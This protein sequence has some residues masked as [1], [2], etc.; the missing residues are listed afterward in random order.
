MSS[1]EV[2]VEKECLIW[3]I[4]IRVNGEVKIVYRH[5]SLITVDDP[6]FQ[7][8]TNA[9]DEHCSEKTRD[10]VQTDRRFHFS[11]VQIMEYHMLMT[12]PGP[13]VHHRC[14]SDQRAAA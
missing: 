5:S 3:A 8:I 9:L 14:V 1:V 4:K 13:E 10:E 11:E 12:C 7:P 2:I 6:I